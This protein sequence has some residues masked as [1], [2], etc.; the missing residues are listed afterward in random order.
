MTKAK[1]SQL[2]HASK[3]AEEI[4]LSQIKQEFTTPAGA[5]FDYLEIVERNINE[6][7]LNASEELNQIKTGGER[8]IEEYEIAFKENTG[9]KASSQKKTPEE[10]SELRH[11]LRTPL[12]A[13]IGYS[14]IL[15]EDLEED[16]SEETTDLVYFEY[17]L[18][19]KIFDILELY[20]QYHQEIGIHFVH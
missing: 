9:P 17:Y 5:I 7:K 16:L 2:R 1:K 8:L 13:V 20:S 12:N 14:E 11:N 3:G 18:R 6:A 19:A 15:M 4:L 10:Y